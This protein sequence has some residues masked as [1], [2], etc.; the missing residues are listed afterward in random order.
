MHIFGDNGQPICSSEPARVA[1]LSWWRLQVSS[2]RGSIRTLWPRWPTTTLDKPY[3]LF[4]SSLRGLPGNRDDLDHS[5]RPLCPGRT[6]RLRFVGLAES[7]SPSPHIP[8]LHLKPHGFVL[9]ETGHEA[10]GSA[11][12]ASVRARDHF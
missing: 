5:G 12:A 9:C 6:R 11:S 10:A 3:R 7:E 4:C 8:L 2:P 1:A